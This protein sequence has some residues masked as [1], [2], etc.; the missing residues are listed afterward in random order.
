MGGY[1][2]WIGYVE[3]LRSATV[4]KIETAAPNEKPRAAGTTLL[5][6]ACT[7]AYVENKNPNGSKNGTLR[8]LYLDEYDDLS[9][10][11]Y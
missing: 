10:G 8:A 5:V 9:D 3:T 6:L 1:G 7:L 4:K 2:S 11:T